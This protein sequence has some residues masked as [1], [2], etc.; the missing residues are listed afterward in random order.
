LKQKLNK[1]SDPVIL[2]I[3]LI[4]LVFGLIM[5]SSAGVIFS[6]VRFGDEYHLLKRHFLYGILIGLPCMYLVSKIKYTFW[7]KIALPFF[8]SVLALL[9]LVLVVGF[10]VQYQGASRWIELGPVSFQPSEIAKIGIIIYLAAWLKNRQSRIEDFKQGLV[11]F[12]M[13]LGLISVLIISQPDIGTLGVIII[14]SLVMF[15]VSGAPLKYIAGILMGGFVLLGL[16]I[17]LEPYRMNRLAA[18]LDPSVDPQGISYQINQA[19][20]AVGSGGVFGLGLGFSRQKFNYLPEPV[21]DS[22]FAIISEELG[23]IGGVVLICFFIA[24]ALRGYKIARYAKDEFS[25]LVAIGITTWIV[26]QALVNIMS[27]LKLMPL[28]GITLPF[29]SYG[30]TSM[31]FTLIAV[32]ILL[33]ISKY[34]QVK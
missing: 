4:L 32:G 14:T 25:R 22:I 34:S 6:N 7:E 13:I 19:L 17:K 8:I 27:I 3:V 21:S 11:P 33:N 28:T 16:L 10:G 20:L 12:L 30:S 18:F 1:K 9:V 26:F 29:I 15:Y 5:I 2:S 23:M 24:F 31:V